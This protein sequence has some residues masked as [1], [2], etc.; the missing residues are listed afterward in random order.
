[1]VEKKSLVTVIGSY[2]IGLFISA[3]RIP[4]PG[5]TL[6]GHS[7]QEH[8]GGKGSNQAVGI[9]R[10]GGKVEIAC[11]IGA[12]DSG[13]KAMSLWKSEGVGVNYVKQ[14]K[15]VSTGIGFIIVDENRENC[16]VF[17]TGANRAFSS[18]DVEDAWDIISQS[19]IALMQMEIPIETVATATELGR[20]AGAKVILN[21]APARKLSKKILSNVDILTPNETET[22]ILT[23]MPVRN[24]KEAISAGKKLLEKGVKQVIITC[25]KDG[26]LLIS[27]ESIKHFHGY[28]VNVVDTTGAGD[29]FNAG[30]VYVLSQGHEI[31]QAIDFANKAGALETTKLGVVPGL[32]TLEEIQREFG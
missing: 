12:D 14:R 8:H 22:E 7:F 2:G 20:K 6:I 25:G 19:Q 5:E 11:C 21:P 29:A 23:D 4:R 3:P 1:M 32:P 15:E 18:A 27:K 16:I 24:R 28:K 9:A 30:L 31:S 10:L 13:N 26:A 17:D